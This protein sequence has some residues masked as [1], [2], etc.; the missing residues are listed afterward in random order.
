MLN[1]Q[2]NNAELEKDLKETYGI[3]TQS[4]SKAFSE[5][6]QQQKIHKDIGISIQQLE[7]GQHR[8]MEDVMQGIRDKYK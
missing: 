6:I 7:N 4:L 8:A 1:L 3:D 2:I 5:F